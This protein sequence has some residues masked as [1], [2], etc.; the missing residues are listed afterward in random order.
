MSRRP[1]SAFFNALLPL[2]AAAL[3]SPAAARADWPAIRVGANVFYESPRS[4]RGNIGP[5]LGVGIEP[6]AGFGGQLTLDWTD[7]IASTVTAG[8]FRPSLRLHGAGAAALGTDGGRV[9]FL[10]ITAV[11]VAKL[12]RLGRFRPYAGAGVAYP[13]VAS[14]RLAPAVAAAGY[15]RL[16]N[17]HHGDLVLDV[18]G[19]LA[20]APRTTLSLDLRYLPVA[21]TVV[22]DTPRGDLFRKGI[23]THPLTL[24]LGIAYRVF[25]PHTYRGP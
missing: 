21:E 16:V 4:E 15:P 7:R 6:A 17:P 23:D 8:R 25:T 22:L 1:L 3:L 20:L 24:T 9:D 18:G 19:D 14:S 2:V 12:R 13:L 5:E 11:V 10:P